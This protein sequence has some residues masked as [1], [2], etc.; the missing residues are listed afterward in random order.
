LLKLIKINPHLY[1]RFTLLFRSAQKITIA[2]FSQDFLCGCCRSFFH[3]AGALLLAGGESHNNLCAGDVGTVALRLPTA[4]AVRTEWE[5]GKMVA[6][7]S[8]IK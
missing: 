6:I 2:F 4:M 3:C 5:N 8:G 7:D 1:N